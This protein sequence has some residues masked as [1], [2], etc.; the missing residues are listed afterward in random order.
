MYM[1]LELKKPCEFF[2]LRRI[3]GVDIRQ[4]CMKCFYGE[5][6]KRVFWN[7]KNA[8]TTIEVD[9]PVEENLLFPPVAY[10]LCGL[11]KN[12]DYPKNTHIAFNPCENS[13]VEVDNEEI[14][15]VIDGAKQI[16]F[17]D[18]KP[19]PAGVFTKRQRTCRNWIFANYVNDGQ[20]L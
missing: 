15:V 5:N 12:F 2:W 9:I 16:H 4:C 17:K 13:T 19:N 18:Y 7:S 1:K 20:P 14:H 8:P 6:D 11:A 3:T 10:Y